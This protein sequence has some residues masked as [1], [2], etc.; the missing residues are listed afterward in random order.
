MKESMNRNATKE[1]ETM[2]AHHL[3]AVEIEKGAVEYVTS[4]KSEEDCTIVSHSPTAIQESEAVAAIAA[5]SAHGCAWRLVDTDTK[6][7]VSGTLDAFPQ[8]K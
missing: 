3:L 7:V 5:L 1:H 6:A 4:F 8:Y 2:T